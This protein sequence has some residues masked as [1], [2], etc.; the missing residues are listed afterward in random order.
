MWRTSLKTSDIGVGELA[1]KVPIGMLCEVEWTRGKGNNRCQGVSC[2]FL[3][4]TILRHYVVVVCYYL[5]SWGKF[6][7][8]FSPP[9]LPHP[10]RLGEGKAA[11]CESEYFWVLFKMLDEDLKTSNGLCYGS[12]FG[13]LG[14]RRHRLDEIHVS[15]HVLCFAR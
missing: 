12:F 1:D 2:C 9:H 15:S 8:R 4:G 11:A 5:L 13:A 14:Y 6:M 7:K 3:L 10:L